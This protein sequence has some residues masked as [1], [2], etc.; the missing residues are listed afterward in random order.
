MVPVTMRPSSLSLREM[1]DAAVVSSSVIRPRDIVALLKLRISIL[2]GLVAVGGNYMAST[3]PGMGSMLNTFG[4]TFL[5]SAGACV[6]NQYLERDLDA[7]MQ[8]TRNRP[9]PGG[10]VSAAAAFAVGILLSIAGLAY[11]SLGCNLAAGATGALA[12]VSYVFW[13]TPLKRRTSLC[14]IVGAIPGAL[15]PVIGWAAA[16]GE[17]NFGAF[18]LFTIMFLWQL[19]HFVAIAWIYRDD[20]RQ[21]GMPMLTVVG[22]DGAFAGRQMMIHAAALLAVSL[23]PTPAQLTGLIY[24]TGALLSGLI[25]LWLCLRW[26][27]QKDRDRA[28][29]VFWASLLHITFLFVLMAVDKVAP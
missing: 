23:L 12:L 18:V 2:S 4:G 6:L 28:R 3:T 27:L 20:Y 24:M 8:R 15:P 7:L 11:L 26:V 16:R 19:P 13:Y 14:T 5:L 29:A 25:Y 9:I 21:A 22:P 1:N 10:T 17:F